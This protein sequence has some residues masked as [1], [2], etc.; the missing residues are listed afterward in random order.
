[1]NLV[2]DAVVTRSDP[3]FA[4]AT[5]ELDRFG[6]PWLTG[7]EVDRCLNSTSGRRIELVQLPFSGWRDLHRVSH[8]RPR[9]AFTCP[10]GVGSIFVRRISSRDS[11]AA[12]MSAMSSANSMRR[13]KS[14]T[15]MTAATRLPRRDRKTGSCSVR[16]RSMIDASW[17]RASETLTG[18]VVDMPQSYIQSTGCTRVSQLYNWRHADESTPARNHASAGITSRSNSSIPLRS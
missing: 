16:T 6:R 8:T 2:N 12:R 10:Q 11:S 14:S 17:P 3:P 15:S 1:M 5:D 4:R 18:S 9:S 13:S 7:Q